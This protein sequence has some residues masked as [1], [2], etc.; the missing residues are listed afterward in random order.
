MEPDTARVLA[1]HGNRRIYD[2]PGDGYVSVE[3]SSSSR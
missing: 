3:T 2:E 1:M